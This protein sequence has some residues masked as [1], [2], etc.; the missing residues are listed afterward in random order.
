M[1][2]NLLL[3]MIVISMIL[4]VSIVTANI[5]TAHNLPALGVVEKSMFKDLV[6]SYLHPS[7]TGWGI[8]LNTQQ[9]TYLVSKFNAVTVKTLPRDQIIRIL[10]DA[11]A[12]NVTNWSGVKDAIKAAI[13][14]NSTTMVTGR[15][16]INKEQYI[17]TG[18]VKTETTFNGTIRA[19]PNY[20]TC[21]TANIS[22]ENCE[23]QSPILGSLSLTRKSAEFESG[24]DRVWAG[25]MDFNSTAYTFVALV[26]PRVGD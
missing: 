2:R 18:I 22:T 8:G 5:T 26:N 1:K 19:K 17:L 4:S 13:D 24:K 11:K 7:I 14:A 16:Q 9:D 12:G 20:T 3:A 25:T 15:I 10:K 23:N 6:Q 21:V